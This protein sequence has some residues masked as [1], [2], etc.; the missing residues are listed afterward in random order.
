MQLDD[1]GLEDSLLTRVFELISDDGDS[2]TFSALF[3]CFSLVSPF[4]RFT[5]FWVS[6]VSLDEI[7]EDEDEVDEFELGNGEVDTAVVVLFPLF[8]LIKLFAWN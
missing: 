3:A 1:D 7:E 6:L 2:A 5:K 4:S 8:K